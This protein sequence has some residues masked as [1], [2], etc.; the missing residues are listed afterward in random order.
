MEKNNLSRQIIMDHY[1]YPH[2]KVSEIINRDEYLFK[3]ALNPSCG[4]EVEVFIKLE[5]NIITDIKYIGS[6]CSI[7]CSSGSIMTEELINK[8]INEANNKIEN[9]N[10]LIT[11]VNYDINLF[12]D[13]ICFEGIKN[14]PARYKCAFI[15]WETVKSLVKGD[16][17]E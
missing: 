12:E 7:C 3:K 10:K 13:A 14:Y 15:S 1:K 4:D 16:K 2:N 6:G 9:F 8:S 17:H 11:G 5:N